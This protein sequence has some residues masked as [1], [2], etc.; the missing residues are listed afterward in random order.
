MSRV[1]FLLSRLRWHCTDYAPEHVLF[2]SG[3]FSCTAWIRRNL[4]ANK[5]TGFKSFR[6]FV[7]SPDTLTGLF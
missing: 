6:V 2:L 3:L 1:V 4:L 7:S 5:G